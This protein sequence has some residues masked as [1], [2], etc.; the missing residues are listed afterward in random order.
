MEANLYKHNG[1]K[2]HLSGAIGRSPGCPGALSQ[3]VKLLC[4][5]HVSVKVNNSPCLYSVL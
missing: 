1:S 5:Y 2:I 3:C 4:N